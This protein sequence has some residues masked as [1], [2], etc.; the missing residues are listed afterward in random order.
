MNYSD[1]MNYMFRQ[2]SSHSIRIVVVMFHIVRLS[3]SHQKI[4]ILHQQDQLW[5]CILIRD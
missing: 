4:S 3:T 5:D 2:V 1:S